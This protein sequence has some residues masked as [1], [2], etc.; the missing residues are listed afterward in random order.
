MAH[1]MVSTV[2]MVMMRASPVGLLRFLPVVAVAV[3]VMVVAV[4]VMVSVRAPM[5]LSQ[6]L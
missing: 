2:V 1:V 6:I 3:V 4:V 5:R